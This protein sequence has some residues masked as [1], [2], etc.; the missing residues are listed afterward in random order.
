MKVLYDAFTEPEPHYAVMIKAD[1]INAVEIYKK[2]DAYWP[3]NPN[4]AAF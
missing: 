2:D 3:K 4:A 1:K